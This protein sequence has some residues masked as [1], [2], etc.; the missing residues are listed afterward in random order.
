MLNHA[1]KRKREIRLLL[2]ARSILS[3]SGDTGNEIMLPEGTLADRHHFTTSTCL[4]I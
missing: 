1:G 2:T 3:M 4:S